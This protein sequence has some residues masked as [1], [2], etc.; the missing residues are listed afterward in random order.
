MELL[1]IK[2]CFEEHKVF[3][4]NPLCIEFLH[5]SLEFYKKAGYVEPYICYF[6]QKENGL[7]GG[8][9]IKG[10]PVNGKVEIAY[11]IFEPYRKQGIGTEVC[12]MLVDLSLKTDSAIKITAK[13]L[14]EYNYS[15]RILK[16]ILLFL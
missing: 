16:K 14:P 3:E 10:Q 15:A 2:Q 12:K 1:P 7:V 6:V 5:I 8:A 11:G 9:A 13:T 4:A